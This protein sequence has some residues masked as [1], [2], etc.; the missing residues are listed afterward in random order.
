MERKSGE[1]SQKKHWEDLTKDDQIV[2]YN[3]AQYLI[4]N[5]YIMNKTTEQLAV[6]IYNSKWRVT[7]S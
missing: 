6:D 5:G 3:R 1:K 7:T 4:D 2:Y